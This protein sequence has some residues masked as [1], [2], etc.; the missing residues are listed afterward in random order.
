MLLLPVLADPVPRYDGTPYDDTPPDRATLNLLNLGPVPP[1]ANGSCDEGTSNCRPLLTPNDRSLAEPRSNKKGDGP[2]APPSCG[3][4]TSVLPNVVSLN[5]TK[6][7]DTYK[8]AFATLVLTFGTVPRVH[9]SRNL[10]Y[11]FEESAFGVC[12]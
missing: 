10:W 2:T 1:E 5:K 6:E 3:E 7:E 9:E 8:T 11:I 4:D 12:P